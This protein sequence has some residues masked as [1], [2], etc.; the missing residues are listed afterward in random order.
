MVN[1]DPSR[2]R[3][4]FHL[5]RVRFPS[6]ID[7]GRLRESLMAEVRPLCGVD[8]P[9]AKHL[10]GVWETHDRV[11]IAPTGGA[12]SYGLA[13]ARLELTLSKSPA[14]AIV[15]RMA[16]SVLVVLT[17]VTG[18]LVVAGFVA[19]AIGVN[20]ATLVMALYALVLTVLTNLRF[21]RLVRTT[22]RTLDELVK[23]VAEERA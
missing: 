19:V 9:D 20:M 14:P 10:Y 15:M 2:W 8:A 22:S 17:N 4:R 13:N 23:R 6:T 5:S 1:P 12:R 18:L 3:Y 16:C 21:L 7:V 11:L